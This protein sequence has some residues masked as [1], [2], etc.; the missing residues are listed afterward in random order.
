MS[1][2]PFSL[3]R[4]A[5]FSD[6]QIIEL[7]VEVGHA[8]VEQIIEPKEPLSKFIFGGKGA[9]KTHLLRYHSYEVSRIRGFA[10]DAICSVLDDGYLAVFLRATG[11]DAARF[12]ATAEVEP[13][14]QQLFGIYLE[15]RLAELVLDA[16]LDMQASSS[17]KYFLNP[18]EFIAELSSS[19]AEIADGQINTLEKLKA[20]V[21]GERRAIDDAVNNHAFTGQLHVEAKF[22]LG[23]LAIGLGRAMPAYCAELKGVPLLYLVDE[24]ENFTAN[25]QKVINTLIR[26]S[27]GHVS[28]RISG[29]LYSMKTQATIGDDEENREGSEY[30]TTSLDEIMRSWTGYSKFAHEFIA[31]RLKVAS[32]DSDKETYST[33]P[34]MFESVDNQN[35]YGSGIDKFASAEVGRQA[36]ERLRNMLRDSHSLTESANAVVALLVEDF[37]PLIQKLNILVFCKKRRKNWTSA[38]VIECAEAIRDDADRYV[39]SSGTLK[40]R[41]HNAY[42]HWAVDLFA[43]CCKEAGKSHRVP[44]AGFK[45]FVQMSCNNPRNLLIILGRAYAIS[46]FRGVDIMRGERLSVELQSAASV[47]AAHFLFESDSNFGSPSERARLAIARLGDLL[48]TARYSMNIP[49]VSP[50][51]VSFSDEGLTDTSRYELQQALNYSFIFEVADGRPDRN[52]HR[53]HRKIHLNPLLA[54]KWQLPVATR[55]DI[56]LP[57]PMINAIFDHTL[58][59]GF[60]SALRSLA[61]KWNDPFDTAANKAQEALFQ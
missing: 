22:A 26:Y 44:Y 59:K 17:K 18:T 57:A 29:R 34:K 3:V 37:P 54:P 4:A 11:V 58:S 32:P 38:T 49:E 52:S 43:Q 35:F 55:G 7:W 5:D 12:E 28:F 13:K 41:Y 33:V 61:A 23:G 27:E 2:N 24:V 51:A 30:K 36:G 14:W 42:G 1:K 50:L 53:L 60:D 15:L 6:E 8:Q 47:E 46:A 31:R 16:L 40:G 20:W 21:L 39:K 45:T 10:K 56:S 9:G 19:I 48:R 25:Q